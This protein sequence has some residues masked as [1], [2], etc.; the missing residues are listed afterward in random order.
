MRIAIAGAGY[1]GLSNG[2][3]L[4]QCNEV[5]CIDIVASKVEKLNRKRSLSFT[6]GRACGFT[7]FDVSIEMAGWESAC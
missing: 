4:A 5:V 1:V 6:N 2:I 7:E 3:L